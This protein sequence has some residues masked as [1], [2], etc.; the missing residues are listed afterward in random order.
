MRKRKYPWAMIV[1]IFL[2]VLIPFLSWYGSWFGRPLSDAQIE[3]YLNDREKPRNVQHA[4]SFIGNK[5]IEGDATMQRWYPTVI[6][7]SRHEVA[8]VR[9][10]A[11]WAMGQDNR[12]EEFH[13]ALLALLRDE[14]AGVRHN[15][16]V[17]LIRFN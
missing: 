10:V 2:F 16:A 7:V 14:D 4:L 13:Q 8:E 15:A 12:N 5:I 11:A 17:Q 3:T 9:K 6:R 1:V